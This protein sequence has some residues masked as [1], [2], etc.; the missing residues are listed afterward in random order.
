MNNDT[1]AL[2]R[3]VESLIAEIS[4]EI[5]PDEDA[6]PGGLSGQQPALGTYPDGKARLDDRTAE[7]A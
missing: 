4:E 1:K 6:G 2:I 3:E 7:R 5:G